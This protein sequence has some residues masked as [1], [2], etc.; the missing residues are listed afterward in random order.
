MQQHANIKLNSTEAAGKTSRD[1]KT[2]SY[3]VFSIPES[4][5]TSKNLNICQHQLQHNAK[6]RKHGAQ[7]FI[8]EKL[9]PQ[10]SHK[11]EHKSPSSNFRT[12]FLG[13][14]TEKE[15]KVQYVH[16]CYGDLQI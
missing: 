8:P 10:N 16:S 11:E 5:Q 13:R 15:H 6:E 2:D 3:T 4:N 1:K 7:I 9:K 14:S 12:R